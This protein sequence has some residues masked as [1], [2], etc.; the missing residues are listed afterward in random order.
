MCIVGLVSH[1]MSR[2]TGV[3]GIGAALL[4]INAKN[5]RIWGEQA[6]DLEF[7]RF[8][9][10]QGMQ[11]NRYK[12]ALSALLPAHDHI[13]VLSF[14]E[15]SPLDCQRCKGARQVGICAEVLE[16]FGLVE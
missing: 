3:L 13:V 9:I 7:R 5:N 10:D 4:G 11:Q 6:P 16:T 12:M 15:R 8:A 2:T 1:Q 14:K